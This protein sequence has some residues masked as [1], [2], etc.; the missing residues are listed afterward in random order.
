MYHTFSIYIIFILKN[1]YYITI[2]YYNLT[3]IILLN[4]LT[5]NYRKM[6]YSSNFLSQSFNPKNY[7]LFVG[8]KSM[9]CCYA[10]RTNLWLNFGIIA[11]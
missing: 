4:N 9:I 6:L 7:I 11:D 3:H 8:F 2:Y 5:N 10:L 1:D